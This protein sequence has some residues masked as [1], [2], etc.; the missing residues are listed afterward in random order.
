[1]SRDT[2]KVAELADKDIRFHITGRS[3]WAGHYRGR[4][5]AL[6][7]FH[8]VGAATG[9]SVRIELHDVVGG[10]EHVVGLHRMRGHRDGKALDQNGCLVCH[11]KDG[12]MTEAWLA[13]ENQRQFDD[14]WV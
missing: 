8:D 9:R 13:F 3:R 14:F 12:L 11:F 2:M 1:M 6:K 5:Q 4:E 10:D 7:V